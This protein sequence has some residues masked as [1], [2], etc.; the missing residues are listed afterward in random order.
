MEEEFHSTSCKPANRPIDLYWRFHFLPASRR[1]FESKLLRAS[2]VLLESSASKEQQRQREEQ[3]RQRLLKEQQRQQR[4]E[5]QK[6]PQRQREEQERQRRLKDEE[7]QRQHERQQREDQER[8]RHRQ[9]NEDRQRQ[10]QDQMDRVGEEQLKIQADIK[11]SIEPLMEKTNLIREIWTA[12]EVGA[13]DSETNSK[14]QP[15]LNDLPLVLPSAEEMNNL[16]RRVNQQ[17]HILDGLQNEIS[18]LTDPQRKTLQQLEKQHIK[19]QAYLLALKLE[20]RPY[21]NQNDKEQNLL[22]HARSG[23]IDSNEVN[24]MLAAL[25]HVLPQ[26]EPIWGIHRP[27]YRDPEDI[28]TNPQSPSA[29]GP[30]SGSRNKG[31][32]REMTTPTDLSQREMSPATNLSEVLET[33]DLDDPASPPPHLDAPPPDGSASPLDGSVPP[34][35]GSALPLDGSAPPLDGSQKRAPPILPTVGPNQFR[36]SERIQFYVKARMKAKED[37]ANGDNTKPTARAARKAIALEKKAMELEGEKVARPK[38][39]GRIAK[40]K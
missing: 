25:N 28:Q 31:K 7:Q 22:N 3:E 20:Q 27:G 2:Y 40:K 18:Q 8:E 36:K 17:K 10:R 35:D 30:S 13:T 1:I 12:Q 4:E 26:S 24:E 6:E 33:M 14:L 15:L 21:P 37:A 5:Q 16:L 11:Y 9:L 38:R 39:G 34:L 32:E 29:G 23:K 19:I